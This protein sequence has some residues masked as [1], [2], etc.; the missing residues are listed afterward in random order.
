M[1]YLPFVP[2]W[3][4]FYTLNTIPAT[5]SRSSGLSFTPS[6]AWQGPKRWAAAV[7][8]SLAFCAAAACSAAPSVA[9]EPPASCGRL[10]VGRLLDFPASGPKVRSWM[11]Q[12]GTEA[13]KSGRWSGGG[14]RSCASCT[15]P[16]RIRARRKASQR[17]TGGKPARDGRTGRQIAK[18]GINR[19]DILCRNSSSCQVSPGATPLSSVGIFA[20]RIASITAWEDFQGSPGMRLISSPHTLPKAAMAS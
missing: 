5:E 10:P 15:E 4:I 11:P 7:R 12:L 13:G 16:A 18:N 1:L 3:G 8:P 14:R 17:K 9:Q 20:L 19:S 6:L 2:F